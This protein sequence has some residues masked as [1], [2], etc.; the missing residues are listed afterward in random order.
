MYGA[1][2]A[3]S[4]DPACTQILFRSQLESEKSAPD[5][6]VQIQTM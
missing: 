5:V 2:A 1:V 6:P 3:V 4:F